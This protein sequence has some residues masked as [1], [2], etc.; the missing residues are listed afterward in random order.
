MIAPR[1]IRGRLYAGFGAMLAI[2]VLAGFLALVALYRNNRQSEE[3]VAV[4]EEQFESSQRV[5]ATLMREI[6]AGMLYVTTGNEPDRARYEQLAVRADSLRRLAVAI[7]SL[8]PAERAQLE[9]IGRLQGAIEARVALATA[10]RAIGRPG[11]VTRVLGLATAEGDRLE[12]ALEALRRGGTVRTAARR[13]EMRDALQRSDR[14]LKGLVL[15]T[16]GIAVVSGLTT[17]R[18]VTRP[19]R[20]FGREVEAIGAGDLRVETVPAITD[21]EEYAELS[22]SLGRAR[23]R[24]RTLL[25]R[26]QAEADTVSEVATALASATSGV[27]DA[28]QS[29]T[30]AVTEMAEG[31][32]SQLDALGRAGEAVGK[33]GEEGTA[34]AQAGSASEEAGRDI[35]RTAGTAREEIAKAVATLLD[36]RAVV[37]SSAS[38]IAV[39]RDAAGVIETFAAAIGEIASQTNLLA[40][41]A[42]IEAAR[43]GDAGRGFSVVAEEVRT[44]A[45][46]SADTA[47]QISDK[48]RVL[49]QRVVSASRA[50]EQGTARLHDVEGVA[51]GASRA[52]DDIEG[53][54]VR[55]ETAAAR[56][57]AVVGASRAAIAAVEAALDSA[58]DTAEGHAAAA[59][60]VAASTQQT[61]ATS[62]ELTATAEA[63]RDGSARVRGLVQEFK[64]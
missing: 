22:A 34:I 17:V 26:V 56:V 55:V 20:A 48:V 19:L 39:L 63:L 11:D 45:E 54:V 10:Y 43:A 28:A 5:V 25:E 2:I 14:T 38:E 51:E 8:S 27:S 30:V 47:R 41:N 16:L 9:E 3:Q 40:L 62:E 49:R 12:S 15:L 32:A 60:E 64:T 46:Q 24:L 33:L 50:V 44:L 4:L 59:Q 6:A 29:I 23:E 13:A 52:V 42:S 57:S 35:R 7:A 58:R 53:A 31:A 36:A 37:N 21:V 61:S 18:A 1:T